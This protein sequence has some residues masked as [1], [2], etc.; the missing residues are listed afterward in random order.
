M[1][2]GRRPGGGARRRVVLFAAAKDPLKEVLVGWTG[3]RLW[4]AL[5]DFAAGVRI[6]PDVRCGIASAHLAVRTRGAVGV[7]ALFRLRIDGDGPGVLVVGQ[8]FDL[9]EGFW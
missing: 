4:V 8:G 9:F 5:L 7:C 6:L 2:F 1:P 3:G